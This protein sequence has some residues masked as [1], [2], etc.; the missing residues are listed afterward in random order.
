MRPGTVPTPRHPPPA[1][2]ASGWAG[3]CALA[4]WAVGPQPLRAF[5]LADWVEN[6]ALLDI[7]PG[8]ARSGIARGLARGGYELSDGTPQRFDDWYTARFPDMTVQFLTPL[9]RD[10]GLIW[11]FGTGE[12]GE[13]YRIDPGLW[14]GLVYRVPLSRRSALVLSAQTMLWGNMREFPCTADYGVLGGVQQV[15][16]RL[17]ASPLPPDET[18]DYLV[19]H[20]GRRETRIS[21]RYELRF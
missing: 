21:I 15:N 10:L 2:L 19:A 7:S 9:R 3:L 11:G 14:L 6:T 17:A 8:S 5:D 18:L 12:R 20:S 13:K 4:L 1:R 16:C